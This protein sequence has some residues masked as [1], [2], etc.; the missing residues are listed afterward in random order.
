MEH[1]IEP[2]PPDSA[3]DMEKLD[4][5]RSERPSDL[6]IPLVRVR[7]AALMKCE[8]HDT[9]ALGPDSAGFQQFRSSR[10][11][12]ACDMGGAGNSVQYV[13]CKHPRG[14]EQPAVA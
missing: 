13:G 5:S 6:R 2:L 14:I 7:R 9:D 10:L 11:A 12:D 3:A 8:V 1:H 4:A